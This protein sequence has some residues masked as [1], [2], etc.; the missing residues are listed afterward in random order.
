MK[1]K[2]VCEETGLSR[3]T[4]RLYEEKGLIAPRKERMN[5]RDYRDYSEEDVAQLKM[6]AML[7][8]AWF[9]MEEIRQMQEDPSSIQEIFP[10]YRQW[11][12]QQKRDLDTLIAVA[13]AVHLSE[14]ETVEELTEHMAAAAASLP[15][16]TAD[17]TPHFRYL[18]EIEEVRNMKTE[19]TPEEWKAPLS[20][21]G[22]Q[23]DRAYRQFV[24]ATSKTND[25]NLAVAFGQLHEATGLSTEEGPVQGKQQESKSVRRLGRIS[26]WILIIGI[27]LFI[28]MEI[29][30][31]MDMGFA[32]TSEDTGITLAMYVGLVLIG[33]GFVGELATRGLAAYQEKQ[34]WIQEMRRQDAEKR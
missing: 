3:K 33:V 22:I 9:T 21:G 25:D 11:L 17:V 26:S 31:Y 18:D 4:I 16:P 34:R 23:D 12:R 30:C 15:L 8:R 27:V 6:I 10:Q 13:D 29:L 19:K 1:F 5:G 24:A 32:K 2:E 7:R 20:S 14:V 28:V